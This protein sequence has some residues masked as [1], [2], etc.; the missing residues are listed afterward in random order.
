M[1]VTRTPHSVRPAITHV[2]DSLIVS[3]G[4]EKQLLANLRAFD[5]SVI[6]HRV[7]LVYGTSQSWVA[8]LPT[9]IG[10]TVL[11]ARGPVSRG[12]AARRLAEHLRKEP[13]DLLH[14]TLPTASFATRIAS[15]LTRTPF[16]ESLVNISHEPIRMQDNPGVTA[17]KLRSHTVLDRLTMRAGVAFHAVSSTVAESWSRVVG[18]PLGKIEVIPRGVDPSSVAFSSEQRKTIRDEVR[19]EFA[20]DPSSPI[21]VSV[22][23]H[24][25]QKGHRYLLEAIA[26]LVQGRPNIRALIVGRDGASTPALRSL[27]AQLGL[28]QNVT[29]AGARRDVSR[30]LSASDVFA[31]PSL[32]EGNGGNAM[33][34]AM[35]HGLPI[36]T[37]GA[38]PMTDLIPGL[39]FGRL[40]D[41]GDAQGIA[42]AVDELLSD[43]DLSSALGESA[44]ERAFRMPTPSQVAMRY[45]DWYRSLIGFG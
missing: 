12:A 35:Q 16:V 15:R 23:R 39:E 36:V 20:M 43:R 5:H 45:E 6:D 29:F 13:A 37:T 22:G 10:V 28:D 19:R 38:P 7:V 27:T 34:E 3:G 30:L 8:D 2:I 44:R 21:V 26:E 1:P 33:I 41:R 25:P 17:W 9:A 24:E 4:A 42:A 14:G 11:F 18:V 40:V 31:F 32:F